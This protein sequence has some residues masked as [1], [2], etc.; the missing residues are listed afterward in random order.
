MSNA[1]QRPGGF[2]MPQR[3]AS[4]DRWAKRRKKD[5]EYPFENV[6]VNYTL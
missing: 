2:P 3:R 5:I 6:A 1:S 4:I